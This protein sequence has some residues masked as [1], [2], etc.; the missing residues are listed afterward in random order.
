[1]AQLKEFFI[2]LLLTPWLLKYLGKICMS[3]AM[4]GII[5]G[6]YASRFDDRVEH[7][8]KRLE[9][10][11]NDHVVRPESLTL[12]EQWPLVNMFVP[13]TPEAFFR[14]A[15]LFAIGCLL[16]YMAKKVRAIQ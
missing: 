14:Y 1:M 11:T 9:A 3:F 7:S 2:T 6:V 10:I 13:E 4:T 5:L 8:F 16:S 12:F 15:A